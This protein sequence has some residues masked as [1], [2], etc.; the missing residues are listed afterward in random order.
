MGIPRMCTIKRGKDW[1]TPRY[2]TQSTGVKDKKARRKKCLCPKHRHR[3]VCT[4]RHRHVCTHLFLKGKKKEICA[5]Y[6]AWP[7]VNQ[8]HQASP[9]RPFAM[10]P[11]FRG[12]C[13]KSSEKRVFSKNHPE[14]GRTKSLKQYSQSPTVVVVVVSLSKEGPEGSSVM[15]PSL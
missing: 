5:P 2:V 7:Y 4:H 8:N 13:S 10:S 11:T 15:H 6:Y 3:H 9:K 1:K 14:N 12:I